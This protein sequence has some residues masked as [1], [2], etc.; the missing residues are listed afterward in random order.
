MEITRAPMIETRY[1]APTNTKPGRV[2]AYYLNHR[3]QRLMVSWDH[4]KDIF[5][6]HLAVAQA[7]VDKRDVDHGK[8]RIDRACGVENG[9]YVFSLEWVK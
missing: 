4:G 5:E 3:K 7:L 9:G 6:N 8:V 2:V 1:I